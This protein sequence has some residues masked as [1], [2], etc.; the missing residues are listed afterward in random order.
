MKQGDH[1]T[2]VCIIDPEN[3]D[4]ESLPLAE[5]FVGKRGVIIRENKNGLTGNTA[6]DPLV[7]V[8]VHGQGRYEFWR[9][10]LD[11]S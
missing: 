5:S 8:A 7:L 10:E 6:E 11:V 2:I 3:F 9:E 4:A 1:V